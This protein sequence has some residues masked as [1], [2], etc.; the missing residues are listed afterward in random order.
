MPRTITAVVDTGASKGRLSVLIGPFGLPGITSPPVS[1]R[2]RPHANHEYSL[3]TVGGRPAWSARAKA[4]GS[5][6]LRDYVV[7]T[8]VIEPRCW[9]SIRPVVH[10]EALGTEG[11]VSPSR[12]V[13]AA[14]RSQLSAVRSGRRRE[15]GKQR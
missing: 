13:I 6:D 12:R 1:R 4:A 2:R 14:A 7:D 10:R 5:V 8:L 3:K 15:S 9:W 11:G